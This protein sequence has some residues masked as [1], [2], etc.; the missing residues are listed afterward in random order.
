MIHSLRWFG[1][2]PALGMEKLTQG[3][4]KAIQGQREKAHCNP[5]DQFD[6]KI[7][8]QGLNFGC[9]G[10]L[11]DL[12]DLDASNLFNDVLSCDLFP[13]FKYIVKI[14]NERFATSMQTAYTIHGQ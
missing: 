8:I 10:S 5:K 13:G 12:P 3:M 4:E 7:W 6:A 14:K 9:S 1:E 2:M 11:N